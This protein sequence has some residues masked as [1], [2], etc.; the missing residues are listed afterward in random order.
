MTDADVPRMRDDLKMNDEVSVTLPAHVWL[1]FVTVYMVAKW[2]N[3]YATMVA[4]A[5]RETIY[6]PRY[7][8]EQEAQRQQHHD[9]HQKIISRMIPGFPTPDVPPD[10]DDF[11]D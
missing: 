11:R 3:P 6:H 2:S 10:A 8:S 4:L 1:A 7:L 9:M 5:A